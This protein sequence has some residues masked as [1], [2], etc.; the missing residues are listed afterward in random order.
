[1]PK[2]FD[3]TA[4]SGAEA[5]LVKNK[6]SNL[7]PPPMAPAKGRR[8][9]RSNKENIPRNAPRTTAVPAGG[10]VADNSIDRPQNLAKVGVKTIRELMGLKGTHNDN[11]WLGI[12]VSEPA[13][14]SMVSTTSNFQATLRDLLSAARVDWSLNWKSQKSKK[15]AELYDAVCLF[16]TH[17]HCS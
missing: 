15:L 2:M 12:R 5:R 4:H 1:M 17:H 13:L 7:S 6:N 16:A 8:N 14:P 9:N 3:S 11:E 10:T